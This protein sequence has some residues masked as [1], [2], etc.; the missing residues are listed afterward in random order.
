LL[1]SLN[2]GDYAQ[3]KH[4]QGKKLKCIQNSGGEQFTVSTLICP[5]MSGTTETCLLLLLLLFLI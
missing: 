2:A 4:M 1:G 5:E 3:D